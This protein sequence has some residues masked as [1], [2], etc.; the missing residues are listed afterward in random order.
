MTRLGFLFRK[1]SSVSPRS[2]Y[3]E[4]APDIHSLRRP[5]ELR[6]R[7]VVLNYWN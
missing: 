1:K 4:Q 7:L 5:V 6:S 3:R 2:E